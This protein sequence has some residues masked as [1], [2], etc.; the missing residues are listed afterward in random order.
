MQPCAPA[1][2]PL[3]CHLWQVPSCHIPSSMAKDMQMFRPCQLTPQVLTKPKWSHHCDAMYRRSELFLLFFRPGTF[4]ITS[5]NHLTLWLV[6]MWMTRYPIFCRATQG[7]TSLTCC[8]HLHSLSFHA[9]KTLS[10]TASI[11]PPDNRGLHAS[12][13]PL[14]VYMH[15]TR[16]T[17]WM[18]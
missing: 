3:P 13:N 10:L 6:R 5:Q 18:V 17:M 15:S 2:P 7:S 14:P 12:S 9:W 1:C 8:S 16:C 4:C 11:P